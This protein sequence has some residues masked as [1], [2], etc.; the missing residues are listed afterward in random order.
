[1]GACDTCNH[2]CDDDAPKRDPDA[3]RSTSAKEG[4]CNFCHRH[5]RISPPGIV[6]HPV[7]VVRGPSFS[8]RICDDCA[9]VIAAAFPKSAR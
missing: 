1:M 3:F 6:D 2:T 7:T 9:P 8:V 4:S 5:L